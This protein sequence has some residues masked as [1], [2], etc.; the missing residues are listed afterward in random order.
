MCAVCNRWPDILLVFCGRHTEI[1]IARWLSFVYMSMVHIAIVSERLIHSI[2]CRIVC[3]IREKNINNKNIRAKVIGQ[4]HMIFVVVIECIFHFE[5]NQRFPL[6]LN[7][8]TSKRPH[9][10]HLASS[11]LDQC[12]MDRA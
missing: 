12:W 2:P 7:V 9:P 10:G 3:G 8:H 5:Q 6:T 4:Q 1:S 11:V